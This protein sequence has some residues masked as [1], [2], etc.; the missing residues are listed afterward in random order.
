MVLLPPTDLYWCSLWQFRLQVSLSTGFTVTARALVV[1]SSILFCLIPFISQLQLHV[2][3]TGLR[4]LP[5]KTCEWGW[6]IGYKSSG[7]K[8]G[9]SSRGC[10]VLPF[11]IGRTWFKLAKQH[12]IQRLSRGAKKHETYVAIFLWLICTGLGGH[13]PLG[14]PWIRYCR[15]A[16]NGS[17][18]LLLMKSEQ[19]NMV[20]HVTSDSGLLTM[21]MYCWIVDL[22]Y[23]TL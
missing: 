15:L 23:L 18:Q 5:G 7:R 13:G 12:W 3:V 14:T 20:G 9:N 4:L 17:Y 16:Q 21:Q 22:T 1:L 6:Y 19:Y 10:G 8:I 2:N 11:R